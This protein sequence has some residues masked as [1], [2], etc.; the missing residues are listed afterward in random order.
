MGSEA[1]QMDHR[2][3]LI[4]FLNKFSL[5]A[6]HVLGAV[7]STRKLHEQIGMCTLKELTLYCKIMKVQRNQLG[8]HCNNPGQNIEPRTREFPAGPMVRTW[9]FHCSGPCSIP[10]WETKIPKAG[11]RGQKTVCTKLKRC[12]ETKRQN[13]LECRISGTC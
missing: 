12:Q 9:H 10:A 5:N 8:T 13:S 11:Q 4:H 3:L 1:G 2:H 7:L 6:Y